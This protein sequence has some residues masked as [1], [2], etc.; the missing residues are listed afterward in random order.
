MWDNKNKSEISCVLAG[1]ILKEQKK[2]ISEENLKNII[3]AANIKI[4]NYWPIIFSRCMKDLE[5]ELDV[6]INNLSSNLTF[7]QEKKKVEKEENINKKK[8]EKNDKE[9]SAK[10]SDDDLGFGLF[11]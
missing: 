1:L 11:D 7:P 5:K 9:D 6:N 2:E 4:E 8:E 10:E 3:K